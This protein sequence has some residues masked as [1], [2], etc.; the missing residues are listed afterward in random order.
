MIGGEKKKAD[1]S[2]LTY[3]LLYNGYHLTSVYN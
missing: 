2:L 1:K 3:R